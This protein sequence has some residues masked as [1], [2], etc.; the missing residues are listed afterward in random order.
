MRLEVLLTEESA[1]DQVNIMMVDSVM[2]SAPLSVE[3]RA[4]ARELV[5]MEF[6][7]RIQMVALLLVVLETLVTRYLI[8]PVREDTKWNA[9][10]VVVSTRRLFN[11][12]IAHFG[13]L[14]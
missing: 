14:G 7:C 5:R 12:L 3:P 2:T 6:V 10:K 4:A 13:N 8:V 11:S 1:V 9:H